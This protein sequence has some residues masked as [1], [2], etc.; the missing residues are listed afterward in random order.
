MDKKFHLVKLI[1]R[2]HNHIMLDGL[3]K[4]SDLVLFFN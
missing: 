2:M 3:K 4:G 1:S